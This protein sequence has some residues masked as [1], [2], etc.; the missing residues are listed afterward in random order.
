MK[1]EMCER[2]RGTRLQ[3][4][5][6]TRKHSKRPSAFKKGTKGNQ[7]VG[8]AVARRAMPRARRSKD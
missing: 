6:Q 7:R 8:S 1:R 4:D 2:E 5:S 3:E